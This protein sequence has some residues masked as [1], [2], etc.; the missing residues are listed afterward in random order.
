MLLLC[1]P[2]LIGAERNQHQIIV[3]EEVTLAKRNELAGKLRAISGWA[4]LSFDTTGAL[5]KGGKD[6]L[7]GSA[8]AR[9]LISKALSGANVIILED[10]SDRAD[11]V[12][13]KVIPGRWKDGTSQQ[14]PVYVVLIDFADFEH[15]IGDTAALNA[16]N[17]GWGVLHELDHV[18][19][20]SEDSIAEGDAGVCEAHI[21]QMRLECN[22][23]RRT[24]Y[25]FTDFPQTDEGA[26]ITR[27][28]RIAFEQQET[29]TGK[30]HR[31]WVVWDAN[32]VGGLN[33]QKQIAMLR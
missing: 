16:F 25:F 14:P 1:S 29:P 21:N 3:R 24:D 17:V 20:D 15:L 27:F 33:Q 30:R 31:Y 12:F 4:D 26:F 13:C 6:P 8:T 19:N 32:R 11:V 28:V 10:A 7:G 22:L 18:V 23:P 2:Q 9:E 5:Q